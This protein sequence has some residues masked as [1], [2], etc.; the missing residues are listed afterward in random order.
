MCW[1]LEQRDRHVGAVHEPEVQ[2]DLP[3][4]GTDLG[5]LVARAGGDDGHVVGD[6]RHQQH[7]LVQ[8]LVVAQVHQQRRGR[9]A[10][11]FEQ[12]HR[13]A[14]HPLPGRSGSVST[15][16]F[17][18]GLAP[19][20]K[21]ATSA[22]DRCATSSSRVNCVAPITRANHPPWGILAICAPKKARSMASSGRPTAKVLGRD[23]FHVVQGQAHEQQG[24]DGHRHRH[25]D[26][27]GGGQIRRGAEAD[28]QADA[29]DHEDPVDDGHVD[30]A[31]VAGGG[32]LDRHAGQVVELHGLD[33][34]R[35]GPGDQRLRRDDRRPSWPDPPAGQVAQ[36]G[37]SSKNGF[38]IAS[39]SREQQ[40]ALTEVVQHQSREDDGE[41]A[42]LDRA[43]VRSGPCR[44]TA[45]RR[46]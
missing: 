44:R 18:R 12:E 5:D 15:K 45:P 22:G 25:R 38:S 36:L 8:H 6:D 29:A 19:F 21:P 13:R 32:V 42:E 26:A 23:Q 7:V 17:D 1:S 28:H 46:R 33:R 37:A 9:G 20:R 2:N 27:V 10:G 11:V 40:R 41:P 3:H 14:G 39:G 43:C 31:P 24:G 16:S 34:Q 4:A 35:E 30:L